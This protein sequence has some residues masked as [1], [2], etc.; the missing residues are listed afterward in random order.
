MTPDLITMVDAE[1]GEPITTESLRYGFRVVVLG[2]PC[3]PRWRT[4]A[5]LSLV[6]PAYFGYDAPYVPVEQRFG[7]AAVSS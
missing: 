4:D 2:I 7:V 1:T 5:G 3:D 6:G